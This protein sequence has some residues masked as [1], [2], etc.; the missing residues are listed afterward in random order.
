VLPEQYSRVIAGLAAEI[1][2]QDAATLL[3]AAKYR[4][5][6]MHFRDQHHGRMQAADW[7][8]VESGLRDA[9]RAFHEAVNRPNARSLSGN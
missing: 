6:M 2:R 4:A 7:E 5:G 8:Q 3:Q 9:Y 1:Y